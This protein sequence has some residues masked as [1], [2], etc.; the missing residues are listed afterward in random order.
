MGPRCGAVKDFWDND[1]FEDG[2]EVRVGNM[3]VVKGI[4]ADLL[5]C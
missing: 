2:D 4:F 5:D 1:L 3:Q